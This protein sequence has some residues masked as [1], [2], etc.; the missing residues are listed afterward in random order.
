MSVSKRKIKRQKETAVCD[1]KDEK[2]VKVETKKMCQVI[3][4][5]RNLTIL[6]LGDTGKK[7]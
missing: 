1:Q 7:I 2:V 4:K 5:I 6:R 3:D